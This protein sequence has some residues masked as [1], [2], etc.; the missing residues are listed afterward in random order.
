MH[1]IVFY[2]WQSDLP[3]A[4]NRSF[5]QQALENVAKVIKA[6][7]TVDVE[8]VIDRD[9]QGVAGAPDIA[10]TIFQKIAAADVVVADVSIIVGRRKGRPAPNPNVLI[11]LGYALRALGD[12]RVVLVFN[13]AYG[14]LEQLPF[15]LKMRRA[16]PYNMPESATD[17]ATERRV[18]EARLDAAIRAAMASA[19]E[20]SYQPT[21]PSVSQRFFTS[22]SAVSC[23]A[24]DL[25]FSSLAEGP[26]KN[27]ALL[28]SATSATA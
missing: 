21:G 19:Q 14:K 1:R 27:G 6:D 23:V 17:R 8:P 24:V 15:D 16:L 22:V 3:N 9:T 12:E 11:E 13:T 28:L 20:K 26:S 25:M 18:L 2:S 5:I 10:K 7:D 4:T